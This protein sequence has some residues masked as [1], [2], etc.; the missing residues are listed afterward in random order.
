MIACK[1]K[2][3]W[4]DK[5]CHFWT[6]LDPKDLESVA[7]HGGMRHGGVEDINRHSPKEWRKSLV[8]PWLL[9]IRGNRKDF[10]S[11]E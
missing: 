10:E 4:I 8:R 5:G 1:S 7:I 9:K 3:L 2:K 6:Q 11:H